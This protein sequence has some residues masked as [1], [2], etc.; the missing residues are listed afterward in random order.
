[1]TI[2]N[3]Q[4]QNDR[5]KKILNNTT[6]TN[7]I[8]NIH[9]EIKTQN[10]NDSKN[11]YLIALILFLLSFIIRSLN[12]DY[13][14]VTWDE[15]HFG[16]FSRSYLNRE[17]YFDVHPPLGK[18]LIALS[19]FLFK[20]NNFDF[21]S[22]SEY[23]H[24]FFINMRYFQV[25]LNSLQ[26]PLIF[27]SL[28]NF[29]IEN[30][31]AL[32][33]SLLF[34]F[35][36]MFVVISRFILLDTMLSLFTCL[37]VY[38]MS[39]YSN[40]IL[41]KYYLF[42]LNSLKNNAQ[43]EN[44][45]K[46]NHVKNNK[47]TQ[48]QNS[49]QNKDNI[50]DPETHNILKKLYQKEHF[51]LAFLGI[52]L[53]CTISVK[54]IGF[55]T[56]LLVGIFIIL[57]IIYNLY[58]FS[59]SF[60]I[61][62]FLKRTVYLI[63]LPI[64]LYILFFVVHFQILKNNSA[65]SNLSSIFSINF[66]D[67]VYTENNKIVQRKKLLK[68][69]VD[70]GSIVTIKS[71]SV[72]LHSHIDTY[73]ES[74]LQNSSNEFQD[75][76]DRIDKKEIKN[77]MVTIPFHKIESSKIQQ[78]TGYNAKDEN[79]YFAFQK[80]SDSA[81]FLRENDEIVLLHM[82]TKKYLKVNSTQNK[83]INF[84]VS[85]EKEL[86]TD[87]VFQ[88]KD[89]KHHFLF[90]D[91]NKD[92][93]DFVRSV[94]SSF[95]LYNKERNCYLA[96]TDRILPFWGHKQH[97]IDCSKNGTRWNIEMN[98]YNDLDATKNNQ[99]HEIEPVNNTNNT[100]KGDKN[101]VK[102]IENS[103]YKI[104][105]LS[106]FQKIFLF[107]NNLIEINISMF[108]TNN[109][110]IIDDEI[111]PARISSRPWE[112][113]IL[114][115]GLRMNHWIDESSSNKPVYDRQGDTNK[116]DTNQKIRNEEKS[117]KKEKNKESNSAEEIND[118]KKDDDK[119]KNN[120]EKNILHK[121]KMFYLFGNPFSWYLSLLCVLMCPSVILN[122]ILEKIKNIRNTGNNLIKFENIHITYFF[123]FILLG[124]LLHYL[125]FFLI[126]RVLYFHHYLIALIF[127]ML[128]I[129]IALTLINKKFFNIIILV[130]QIFFFYL[131]KE[132]TYG[133]GQDE[134]VGMFRFLRSWD[135]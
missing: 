106:L 90:R 101:D 41:Q 89:V 66:K 73:P 40:I 132:Y 128:F 47:D 12:L 62:H 124:Y 118:I 69:Y 22:A 80:V 102:Y 95:L 79:N 117:D 19:G 108:R 91:K 23:N 104:Y 85:C 133:F 36:N 32:T 75:D 119:E 10:K 115:R 114:W 16:K 51:A 88:I 48:N 7:H 56:I 116:N 5:V 27:L 83:E 125:P 11:N 127:K 67:E 8:N 78:V 135:F 100:K 44:L 103:L 65:E 45:Q 64:F 57:E 74:Y 113:I 59:K 18:M 92:K 30:S 9:N 25:F 33:I 35:E 98:Y 120:E 39:I 109:S 20:Q 84:L 17:F 72:Y 97:Q 1:M 68:K 134:K 4:K 131:G 96:K 53:G 42:Y 123:T 26:I 46:S 14:F 63:F 52:S 28:I 34:V 6:K 58:F 37:C 3:I 21:K 94:T 54:W 43:T 105:D 2:K 121:H 60:I 99:R 71:G 50:N 81:S 130:V 77:K 82:S 110:F 93:D 70:Y 107:F 31:I 111:E 29:K 38:S 86:F 55:F 24:I 15:A 112:W 122:K 61:S 76:K 13:P 49:F 129:A 87:S 126:S